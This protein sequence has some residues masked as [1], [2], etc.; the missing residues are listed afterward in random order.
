MDRWTRHKGGVAVTRDLRSSHD[1]VAGDLLER[2]GLHRRHCQGS[3][4]GLDGRRDNTAEASR[5]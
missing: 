3:T 4:H 1:Q 2:R 5:E